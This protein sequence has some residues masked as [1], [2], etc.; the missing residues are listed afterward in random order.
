MSWNLRCVLCRQHIGRSCF[1][2]QSGIIYFLSGVFS[3]FTFNIIID[4]AASN[5]SLVFIWEWLYFSFIFEGQLS[6]T[7]NSW[8]I[9]FSLSR[10]MLSYCL[11]TSTVFDETSSVDCIFFY[12]AFL[13]FWNS[14]N[15]YIDML[16]VVPQVS[17]P[18][19]LFLQLLNN[20]CSLDWIISLASPF[21][22][23][24]FPSAL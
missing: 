17:E 15:I 12:T 2:I 10:N 9:D 20:L 22:S 4:T 6:C 16:G 3:L 7:Q 8:L 14:Y 19:F 24:I 23:L 5:K 18:L 21:S 11:L 1:F 13:F